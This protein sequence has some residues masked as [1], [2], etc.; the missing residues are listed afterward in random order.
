[1]T[2]QINLGSTLFVLSIA[3][4][5]AQT[6]DYLPL[7]VGNQWIYRSPDVV[8]DPLVLDIPRAAFL[9]G[10]GYVLLRGLPDGEVWLRMSEDRTLYRYNPDTRREEVWLPF[11]APVGQRFETTINQC[12]PTGAIESRQAEWKGPIGEFNNALEVEYHIGACADGGM[13]SDFYLPYVGLV[14]RTFQTI[15]GPRSIQ[16]VYAR[17]GGVTYVSAPELSVSLALDRFVYPSTEGT[18]ALAARLTLRNTR[19]D[20]ISLTFPSSQRFDLVIR[21]ERGN[22]VY[23]W[24]DGK[25]FMEVVGTE[26]IGSGERNYAVTVPLAARGGAP[27][28]AGRYTTEAWLTNVSPPRFE[29][30]AGFEI[31]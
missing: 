7:Q 18:P 16:L 14:Q 29:A 9:D 11:G 17:L 13:L 4:C 20:P 12:N 6:P 5:L 27:L 30:K 31:R 1:M 25:V 2:R 28:P 10:R 8:T 15:A 21:D 19:L 24:S 22:E 26:E 3:A 23:R